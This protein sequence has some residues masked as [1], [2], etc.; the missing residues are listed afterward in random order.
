M[1][2]ILKH[3]LEISFI[4]SVVVQLE[5]TKMPSTSPMYSYESCVLKRSTSETD[6]KK[7]IP[8]ASDSLFKH[9]RTQSPGTGGASLR[10][11]S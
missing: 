1:S 2:C 7:G 6:F 10:I 11:N 8:S 4:I 3:K 9:E 5:I